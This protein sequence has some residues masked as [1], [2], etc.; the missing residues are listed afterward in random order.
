VRKVL[1]VLGVVVLAT[2]VAVTAA[3]ATPTKKKKPNAAAVKL[4][5]AVKVCNSLSVGIQGPYTGRSA[6]LGLEQLRWAQFAVAK[7][8]KQYRTSFK[9]V[10][11]DDQLNPSQGSTVAQQFIANNKIMAVVGP[12]GSSVVRAVGSA[13][14]G[15]H[16]AL[17]SPSATSASL[18]DGA[19]PTFFRVVPNDSQQAPADANFMIRKLHAQK[20]FILDDQTSYGVPLADLAS[21]VLKAHGVT[22]ARDSVN[23]T[24]TTD[25][26]AII[27]KIS[28][29]T[30][31]IFIPWQGPAAT[32]QV[33]AEQLAEQGKKAH[34][35]GT[36]G[37]Y[38]PAQFHAPG[39]YVSAFAPDIHSVAT[40]KALIAEY[41]KSRFKGDWGTYGPPVYGSTLIALTAMRKSCVNGKASRSEVLTNV[42][43]TK[44]PNWILGG[45]FTFDKNGDPS[46]SRFYIFGINSSG[47]YSLQG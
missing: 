43:K 4:A 29:D 37:E 13:Y 24:N 21:A 15:A 2:T 14:A 18:T 1:A 19:Y 42:S 10:Q 44:I 47:G 12:A 5:A 34:L 23:L 6:F 32:A 8:N 17:I 41:E 22:V 20:V 11:G 25:F 7:F 31:V 40:D 16:I 28:S 30:D 35:F 3:T 26:S 36:D 45:T 33:F 38:N 9:L 39:G 27:S 46:G